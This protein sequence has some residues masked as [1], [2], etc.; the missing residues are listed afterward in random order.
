MPECQYNG[1]DFSMIHM[2][3]FDQEAQYDPSGTD[4]VGT[5]V[6]IGLAAVLSGVVDNTG[7]IQKGNAVLPP[8]ETPTKSNPSVA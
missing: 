1:I 2:V 4:Y 8:T 3:R 6:S 7:I 5:K